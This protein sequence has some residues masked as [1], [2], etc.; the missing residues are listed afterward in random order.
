M[1]LSRLGGA[2]CAFA[3]AFPLSAATRHRAVSALPQ[4]TITGV[5]R[6]AATGLPV[7]G[8][9]VHSGSSF[10]NRQGTALDGKYTLTLPGGR[11]TLITAEDFSFEP[12]TATLTPAAGGTLDFDLTKPRPA[13]T[14]KLINGESHVLDLGTSQFA[15]YVVLS[16][17]VRFDNANLCKPDGSHIAP[18]KTDFVRIVGPL[19]PV[20]SSACCTLGPIMAANIELKSGEKMQAY[21]SE[22]CFGEIDFI[23][24]ERSTAQYQFFNF[25]NIQEIDFP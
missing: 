3:I 7:P 2:F 12:V 18:A 13:V 25:A 17:Y 4:V 19:T 5:V 24:R 21:F 14:I 20:N 11:A 15:Y 10:S 23:G 1:S 16:G 6:D 22:S 8:A 9:I